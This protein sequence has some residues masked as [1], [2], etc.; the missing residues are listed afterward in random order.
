M[1]TGGH[2]SQRIECAEAAD[3]A[4]DRGDVR[5]AP[6]RRR[7]RTARRPIIASGVGG[8]AL[9]GSSSRLLTVDG[10]RAPIGVGAEFSSTGADPM[11]GFADLLGGDG[12][13]STPGIRVR[14]PGDAH[15]ERGHDVGV[16]RTCTGTRSK[17][18]A[19][20]GGAASPR[21]ARHPHQRPARHAPD[22]QLAGA[23]NDGCARGL[24]DSPG[25]ASPTSRALA[26]ERASA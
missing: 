23:L 16:D 18:V 2:G 20:G 5:G 13:D 1:G 17:P 12:G 26:E 14:H 24:G 8:G 7:V 19:P 22:L 21:A 4:G 15:D 3:R 10:A 6:A 11:G 25:R 9:Q